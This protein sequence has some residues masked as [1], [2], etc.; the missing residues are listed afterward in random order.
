MLELAPLGHIS[1][2]AHL[3]LGG[4]A[5]P[6]PLGGHAA[7]QPGLLQAR[8][9]LGCSAGLVTSRLGPSCQA[10]CAVGAV[11]TLV[12]VSARGLYARN[13]V[14]T[15]AAGADSK[16]EGRVRRSVRKTFF[17]FPASDRPVD[18]HPDDA[19]LLEH[20]LHCPCT[21][22][23]HQTSCLCT[24]CSYGERCQVDALFRG[25]DLG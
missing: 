10:M 18:H 23:H 7:S 16:W 21:W 19:V 5:P 13:R 17:M 25:A 9:E 3:L 1:S 14:S 20:P 22:R 8:R 2:A 15:E 4:R 11:A 24:P 12:R 6:L